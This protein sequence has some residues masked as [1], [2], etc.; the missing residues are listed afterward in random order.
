MLQPRC[1]KTC[2]GSLLGPGRLSEEGPATRGRRALARAAVAFDAQMHARAATLRG[3]PRWHQAIRDASLDPDKLTGVFACPVGAAITR[4]DTRIFLQRW[5]V[6]RMTLT[7]RSSGGVCAN[8]LSE[9]SR[10]WP[11]E[12]TRMWHRTTATE[13]RA[14]PPPQQQLWAH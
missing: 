5:P 1:E 4:K 9:R 11:C 3:T 14:R 6:R 8:R 10:P 12:G 7:Q 13:R 2:P